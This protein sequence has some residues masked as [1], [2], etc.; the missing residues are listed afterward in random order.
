MSSRKPIEKQVIKSQSIIDSIVKR[1]K[2]ASLKD[3]IYFH[4]ALMGIIS[5]I[6][7]SIISNIQ[8]FTHT[9]F[10]ITFF[11][12]SISVGACWL[13]FLFYFIFAFKFWGWEEEMGGKLNI[14][15][16]G[17]GAFVFLWIFIW[18]IVNTLSWVFF[19]GP[20]PIYR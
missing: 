11:A 17:I 7:C 15:K 12:Q 18:T 3:K 6:V 5:A 19:Y 10:N 4:R 8:M 2:N 20:P 13:M 14:L 9:Q 1:Y 16:E